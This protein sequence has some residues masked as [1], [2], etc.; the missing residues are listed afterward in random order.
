MENSKLKNTTGR[1]SRIPSFEFFGFFSSV[2]TNKADDFKGLKIRD[3]KIGNGT[4]SFGEKWYLL[5]VL[6]QRSG[7]AGIE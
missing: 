5:L 7:N 4:N 6:C 2:P 1:D 3:P